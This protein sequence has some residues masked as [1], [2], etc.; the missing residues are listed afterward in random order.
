MKKTIIYIAAMVAAVSCS[1]VGMDAGMGAG[2]GSGSGEV[3]TITATIGAGDTKIS[4]D[5]TFDGLKGS[6]DAEEAISV[7]SLNASGKALAYDVFTSTGAAG[8]KTAE[9]TGKLS[10]TG[11]SSYVCYYP[12]MLPSEDSGYAYSTSPYR[13]GATYYRTWYVADDRVGTNSF[14]CNFLG[15]RQIANGDLSH[16]AERFALVGKPV[17]AD[18]TLSVEM[19]H[20]MSVFKYEIKL[21][22]QMAGGRLNSFQMLSYAANKTRFAI[23]SPGS[24][25]TI[26]GT[27]IGESANSNSVMIYCG[28]QARNLDFIDIPGD[29][30]MTLYGLACPYQGEAQ[31]KKGMSFVLNADCIAAGS[32]TVRTLAATLTFAGPQTITPG[33]LYSF[34]ATLE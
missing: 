5:E 4:F 29:G 12:A 24:Y 30:K 8:R 9:F 1:K 10:S 22:Q 27:Q 26:D 23:F 14:N 32:S 3:M 25:S 6:W 33:H 21:P 15:V 13:V 17:V 31:M 16:L 7:V 19:K 28:D 20:L 34:S 2:V 18:G 11:A